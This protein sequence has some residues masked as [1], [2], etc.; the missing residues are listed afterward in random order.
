MSISRAGRSG[1]HFGYCLTGSSRSSPATYDRSRSR[2]SHI[3]F[4]GTA[5]CDCTCEPRGK[6]GLHEATRLPPTPAS[7]PKTFA[8]GQCVD[9]NLLALRRLVLPEIGAGD[10]NRTH[11]S[12]LGS[13]GITI[14][15]RPRRVDSMRPDE[16]SANRPAGRPPGAVTT[17]K[18]TC[19]RASSARP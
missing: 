5:A 12:S 7:I 3:L 13:L 8:S 18:P 19:R 10:G 2:E 16:G 14:I 6:A 11:G 15:R 17:R 1:L 9:A 4:L